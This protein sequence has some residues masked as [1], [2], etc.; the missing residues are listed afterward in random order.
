MDEPIKS[1]QNHL[2]ASV[3]FI[4]V[5]DEDDQ[6]PVTVIRGDTGLGKTSSLLQAF[7]FTGEIAHDEL[8][9]ELRNMRILLLLPHWNSP[10]KSPTMLAQQD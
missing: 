6:A 9:S 10:T 1:D 7:E 5:H 8:A 3:N 4:Q 2:H